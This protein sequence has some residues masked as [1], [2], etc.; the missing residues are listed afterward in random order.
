MRSQGRNLQQRGG[1]PLHPSQAG[2]GQ[3]R[4]STATQKCK[5]APTHPPTPLPQRPS[6][7]GRTA[8]TATP[9]RVSTVRQ[10]ARVQATPTQG[11]TP[12]RL[13]YGDHGTPATHNNMGAMMPGPPQIGMAMQAQAMSQSC[14]IFC[15]RQVYYLDSQS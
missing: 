4:G 14:K 8:V 13:T 10:Q 3:G 1:T 12:N 15:H 6:K 2:H 9:T 7:K 5:T 11:L